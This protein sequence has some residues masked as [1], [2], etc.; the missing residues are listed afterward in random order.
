MQKA[1][2]IPRVMHLARKTR[3]DLN[4]SSL[5]DLWLCTSRKRKLKPSD[6]LLA[7]TLQSCNTQRATWGKLGDL[8]VKTF[9]EMPV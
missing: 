1:L 2:C 7:G 6:S 9:N 4:F 8:L 5:T 3:E